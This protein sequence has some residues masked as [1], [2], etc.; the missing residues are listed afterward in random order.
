MIKTIELCG[1]GNLLGFALCVC[2]CVCVCVWVGG[3]L[4]H[5]REWPPNTNISRKASIICLLFS[6]ENKKKK[7]G[8]GLKG[9]CYA[10]IEKD[11][12]PSNQSINQP[13]NQPVNQSM[14]M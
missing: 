9:L 11:A 7:K 6:P 4:E 2:V 1:V 3:L 10:I 13:V 8:L 14:Y 12:Q 5:Q